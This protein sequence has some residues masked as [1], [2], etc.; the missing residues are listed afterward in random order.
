MLLDTKIEDS[1]VALGISAL[2]VKGEVKELKLM[3]AD[4][5]EKLDPSIRSLDKKF[6][7][8][9]SK[10]S[11]VELGCWMYESSGHFFCGCL[12]HRERL[13]HKRTGG[14]H[15]RRMCFKVTSVERVKSLEGIKIDKGESLRLRYQHW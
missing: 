1:F 7:V 8:G 10:G 12:K 2:S 13:V 15:K 5:L 11:K 14:L 6:S 4:L 9:T 3:F